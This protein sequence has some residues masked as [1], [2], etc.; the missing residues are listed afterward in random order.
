VLCNYKA[1]LLVGPEVDEKLEFRGQLHLQIARFC[2]F[3]DIDN[4]GGGAPE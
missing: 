2:A 3:Q 4:I 1:K